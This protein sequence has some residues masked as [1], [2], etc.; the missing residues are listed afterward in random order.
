M[1]VKLEGSQGTIETVENKIK[2]IEARNGKSGWNLPKR[3]K[4]LKHIRENDVEIRKE[5]S[6]YVYLNLRRRN[7]MRQRI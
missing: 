1:K 4:M 7:R 2:D 5:D 3:I 6:A